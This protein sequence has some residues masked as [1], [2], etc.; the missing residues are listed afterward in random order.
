MYL[1][2]KYLDG[3]AFSEDFL[4]MLHNCAV[5][6]PSGPHFE[7]REQLENLFEIG[8]AKR[9]SGVIP[10]PA[11]LLPPI[12]TIPGNLATL[13]PPIKTIPNNLAL[14]KPQTGKQR[15]KGKSKKNHRPMLW[16]EQNKAATNE[17]HLKAEQQ[18][19]QISRQLCLLYQQC[20]N[21]KHCCY[22]I[23]SIF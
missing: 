5:F 13:P 23:L 7:C 17:R 11:T 2:I 14:P 16:Q 20:L 4:L 1:I 21:T 10:W 9:P 8:W 6:N 18:H 22:Q 12:T 3:A 15:R 19:H